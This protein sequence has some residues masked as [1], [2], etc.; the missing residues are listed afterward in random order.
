MIGPL[1]LIDQSAM[2]LFCILYISECLCACTISRCLHP[3]PLLTS[4]LQTMPHAKSLIHNTKIILILEIKPLTTKRRA[5]YL[6]TQ[7][8]PRRLLYLKT[9][10][11]QRRLL[12]LKTQFIPRRLLYLKTQFVQHRPLYLKTQ[13]VPRRLLYL[14]TQFVPRRLLYLKTQFVPRSK[15]FISVIKIN[16]LASCRAKVAACSQINTKPINTVWEECTIFEC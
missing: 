6:K 2:L 13:F 3:V 14:K 10:F 1:N 4:H 16:Q 11:V 5:L 8:V 7:F 12:Y 9:Q 15:H